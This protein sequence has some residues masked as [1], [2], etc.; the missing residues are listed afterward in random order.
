MEPEGSIPCSQEPS[1]LYECADPG[2]L[3]G[4]F[5]ALRSKNK[6]VVKIQ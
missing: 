1:I 2:Y 6:V 3:I 4:F 5:A